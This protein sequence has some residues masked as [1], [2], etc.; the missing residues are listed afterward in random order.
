[1]PSLGSIIAKHNS[2]IIG[3]GEEVEG[4]RKCSCPEKEKPNCPLGGECLAANIIYQAKVKAFPP[5]RAILEDEEVDPRTAQVQT[6]LGRSKPT[7]KSRKYN[8]TASFDHREKKMDSGL[9]QYIWDLKDRGWRYKISWALIKKSSS[10]SPA[11]DTCRLCLDEKHLLM[12]E[13]GLGTLNVEN[14]FYASCRH[15]AP[16]LLSKA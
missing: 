11:T 14:E 8:H 4:Q 16:L 3:K 5:K 13:P 2:K 6:Y 1:M 9:S 10:Y 12:T 15:K 7:W